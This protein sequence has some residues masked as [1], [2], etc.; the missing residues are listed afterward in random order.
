M[1]HWYPS[2][3][4]RLADIVTQHSNT[5]D[6]GAPLTPVDGPTSLAKGRISMH[7]CTKLNREVQPLLTTFRV[8]SKK[9]L[10]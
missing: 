10:A 4:L 5:I 3:Q 7:Y 8:P 2:V 9:S 1:A 6:R